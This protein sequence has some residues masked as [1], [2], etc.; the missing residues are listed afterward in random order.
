MLSLVKLS[1]IILFYFTVHEQGVD[2]TSVRGN[3]HIF[4]TLI[5]PYIKF[6]KALETNHKS[7][8]ESFQSYTECSTWSTNE[9]DIFRQFTHIVFVLQLYF[10]LEVLEY[11]KKKC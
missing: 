9:F 8:R 2:V 11:T 5:L 4:N 3:F 6:A 10:I 1:K 7:Y